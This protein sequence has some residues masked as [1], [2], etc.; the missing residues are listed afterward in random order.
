MS[1]S[2]GRNRKASREDHQDPRNPKN[3]RSCPG[4]AVGHAKTRRL[5]GKVLYIA[6][7]RTLYIPR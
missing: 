7:T 6:Q 1:A 4:K 2:D 5:I 3:R